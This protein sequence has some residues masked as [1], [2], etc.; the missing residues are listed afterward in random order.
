ME[1]LL[2]ALGAVLFGGVFVGL[3]LSYREIESERTQAAARREVRK[4][5]FYAWHDPGAAISEELMLR[6]IEHHLRREAF[7]AEQFV[8]NPTP[9]TLR[10]GERTRL[11]AN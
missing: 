11:G 1:L 4:P 8:R 5:V 3:L 9:Q 2:F 7:L 10:A 6:Q